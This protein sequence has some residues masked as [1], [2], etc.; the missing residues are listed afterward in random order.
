MPYIDTSVL[1]A[2]YCPEPLSTSAQKTIR[3][4]GVPAI[5]PLVELEFCSALAIKTRSGQL[6]KDAAQKLLSVFLMHLA[7]GQYR[8]VSIEAREYVVAREWISSFSTPLRAVDALHLSAAFCNELV[9]V[10]A[11]K[12]LSAAAEALGV[13]YE[14]LS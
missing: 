9:L 14:L 10:T 3:G 11:D 6:T 5:S 8:S 7:E 2:Y 1:V 13:K 4:R 12:A